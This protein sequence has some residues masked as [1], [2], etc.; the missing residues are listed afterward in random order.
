MK[1]NEELLREEAE[2]MEVKLG[3]ADRVLR[4]IARYWVRWNT[5][6]ET[7]DELALHIQRLIKPYTEKAWQDYIE[8]MKADD[9]LNAL[10]I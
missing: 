9:P 6:M 10:F 7:G 8:P 3:E 1:T 4:E 5:K 2:R